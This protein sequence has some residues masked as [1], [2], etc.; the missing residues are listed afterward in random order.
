MLPI[1]SGPGADG[2]DRKQLKALP[3]GRKCQPLVGSRDQ[4]VLGRTAPTSWDRVED[5]EALR[6]GRKP[7]L[8]L[9]GVAQ[10][11][12]LF[13]EQKQ[14]PQPELPRQRGHFQPGASLVQM[15]S[16][17]KKG[18]KNLGAGEHCGAAQVSSDTPA[19]HSCDSLKAR[20]DR[21]AE[22]QRA[23]PRTCRGLETQPEPQTQE[24]NP[25]LPILHH[26]PRK[27]LQAGPS[28][29]RSQPC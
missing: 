9:L 2:G 21:G 8:S 22:L 26:H 7:A 13:S 27:G 11:T 23:S 14:E 16:G 29:P 20:A 28:R 10:E 25:R 6:A 5:G 1:P 18:L 19:T 3:R 12:M 24:I 15:S 17:P 4:G